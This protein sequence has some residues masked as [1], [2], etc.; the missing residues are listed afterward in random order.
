MA[1]QSICKIK[2]CGNTAKAR[3]LCGKHY[4]R[5]VAEGRPAGHER[6]KVENQGRT[7]TAPGCA[8]PAKKKGYCN[9]HHLRWLR[10]GDPSGQGGTERGSVAEYLAALIDG[11]VASDD[12]IPWPFHRKING[13]GEV[14]KRDGR[15]GLAHRR[16]CEGVNGPPPAPGMVAAHSCGNGHLGCVNPRHLRWAT[17]SENLLDSVKHGTHPRGGRRRRQR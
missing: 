5:W 11:S 17:Y 16:V 10:N 15:T 6:S 1:E 13:Y 4:Q 12:C 14:S 9:A 2:D 3:G 7:C 8:R